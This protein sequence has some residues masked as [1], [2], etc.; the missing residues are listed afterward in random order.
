MVRHFP[1]RSRPTDNLGGKEVLKKLT[2]RHR[3]TI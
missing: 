3:P 1:R 2:C